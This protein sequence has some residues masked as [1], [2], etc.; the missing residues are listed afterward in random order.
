MGERMQVGPLIYNILETKWVAQMGDML[1]Q[2]VPKQRFLLIKVSVTNSG[3]K[4]TSVPF[5]T[6]ENSKGES[7]PE[8]QSGE[9]VDN[10]LG[11]L[12]NIQP[13]QTEEGWILFDVLPNSYSLRVAA[14]TPD[15]D[16]QTLLISIP[17]NI[18]SLTDG[19]PRATP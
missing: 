7:F 10:W 2:R 5:L 8:E 17:F 6:L 4:E 15:G 11:F 12:R 16:E 19:L 14:E 18:D 1:H 3:G 9:G 13:A